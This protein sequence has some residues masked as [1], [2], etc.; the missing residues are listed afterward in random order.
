[1]I[2]AAALKVNVRPAEVHQRLHE[3]FLELGDA[4]KAQYH[5]DQ[6]DQLSAE[7]TAE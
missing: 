7:K 4:P 1:M 2:Y 3:L 6:A 5:L